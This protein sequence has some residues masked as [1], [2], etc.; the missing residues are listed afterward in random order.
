MKIVVT[1]RRYW[2]L[3]EHEAVA[4]TKGWIFESNQT[5]D[6]IIKKT[7][8]SNLNE[9]VFSCPENTMSNKNE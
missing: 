5:L 9:L 3:T 6:Q 7:G 2:Q 4:Y 8:V 1:S